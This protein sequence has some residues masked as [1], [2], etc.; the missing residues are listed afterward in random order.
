MGGVWAFPGG[1]VEPADGPGERRFRAAAVR[2]LAEE[3]A[4]TGVDPDALVPFARWIA[5]PSLRHRFDTHFFLAPAP[6]GQEPVVDGVECVDAGWF[7]PA[8]A[9]EQERSG[10]LPLLF[11]TRTQ[12]QRA[13]RVRE[14]RR[15]ARVRARRAPSRP[16]T[17]G[18]A[19]AGRPGDRAAPRRSRLR[20][21]DV[22]EAPRCAS[23]CSAAPPASLATAASAPSVSRVRRLRRARRGARL[24]QRLP[25][26]APLHGPRPGVL[27]ADP[28]RRTSR[29]R[30]ARCAS[31]TAVTV[32][33]WQPPIIVA[34]QAATVDVLSGGRLDLGV[35]RG[36]RAAE[37]DGFG[38]SIEEAAERHEEAL[39]VILRAWRE[40]GRWSHR[41]RFY[42]Y[43]DVLV[44]PRAGAVART[45]RS[46]SAPAARRAST[47][48]RSAAFACCSTR[49]GASK[50][51]G[52]R[53]A[54]YRERRAQL[55]PGR[56]G[57]DRRDAL[58][59]PRRGAA[60]A[61][62]RDRGP[63]RGVRADARA[64]QPRRR[65]RQPHGRRLQRRHAPRDR[66]GRD[67]R[68]RPPSARSGS[69][70]CA[71]RAPT[72]CC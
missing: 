53:I 62:R 1:A 9:L 39:E 59:A 2:E 19:S 70:R 52:R 23:D 25:H 15:A 3:T 68:R 26:R 69:R 44:E 32:L 6:D 43:N 65:P 21:G 18:C 45:R 35:G 56:P 11:P 8:G 64:D 57:R 63:G 72:T 49:S 51:T 27:A 58:A 4:I 55:G 16:S 12:L 41:G 66:G 7:T 24:R 60:R 48:P 71:S 50:L 34:E 67:H 36:F 47:T 31:G 33:P 46:G 5:P 40:P 20:D 13:A 37:F 42:A 10:A 14:R 54:A 38:Q 29:A 17:R 22:A 30:R 61:R 28:A